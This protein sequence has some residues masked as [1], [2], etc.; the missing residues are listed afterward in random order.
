MNPETYRA[1]VLKHALLVYARTGLKVNTAYTV[2]NMLKLA[3]QYTGA[4]YPRSRAGCAS[5]A[6][7]MVTHLRKL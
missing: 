3:T 1:L 6:N 2:T 4:M 7:D 5:A